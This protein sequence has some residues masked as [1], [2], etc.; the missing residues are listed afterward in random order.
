MTK[1]QKNVIKWIIGVIAL[2]I[3]GFC[4]VELTGDPQN[5]DREP[6]LGIG[7]LIGGLIIACA[8]GGWY[9]KQVL[10]GE[11]KDDTKDGTVEEETKPEGDG[12]VEVEE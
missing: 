7:W 9:V 3:G 6:A 5:S 8:I 2:I 1:N 11:A 4:I 10:F 12:G